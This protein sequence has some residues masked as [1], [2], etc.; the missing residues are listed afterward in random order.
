[1][2]TSIVPPLKRCTKC[3][4]ERP[5]TKEFFYID[6]GRFTALC[7]I[8]H[9]L[10]CVEYRKNN[11][12]KARAAVKN[13]EAKK[14]DHYRGL[15]KAWKLKN[16]DH[17]N[18]WYREWRHKNPERSK[19]HSKNWRNKN[20]AAKKQE[21][22]RRRARKMGASGSHT[23]EDIRQIYENQEQRC[24][25]CGITLFWDLAFDVNVDHYFPLFRGGSDNPDNLRCTCAHCN[26]TKHDKTY[27]EWVLSR[28]W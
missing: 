14:P 18:E 7:K 6:R 2:D 11:P 28:G 15:K 20:P 1:M 17:V 3:F 27:D 25:Y 4:T 24:A 21:W 23:Q 22:Q 16:R 12:E 13:A 8:C 19:K 26:L 9:R 5:E 10:K